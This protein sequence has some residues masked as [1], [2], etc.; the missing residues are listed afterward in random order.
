[1]TIACR[2]TIRPEAAVLAVTGLLDAVGALKVR[3]S[4]LK[5]EAQSPPAVVVDVRGMHGASDRTL[6]VFAVAAARVPLVL[7]GADED[8]TRRLRHHPVLWRVPMYPDRSAALRA[9]S[10]GEVTGQ[11][12]SI[13]LAPTP[14]APAAGRDLVD[15]ALSA[16]RLS[17]LRSEA[18]LVVS[19]LC[20]NVVRH[21]GTAMSVSLWRGHRYLHIEVRDFSRDLPETGRLPL[22]VSSLDHGRGLG[23]VA[24]YSLAWGVRPAPDGKIVWATLRLPSG[25]GSVR[26]SDPT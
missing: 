1:M 19:E 24:A 14:Q 2:T 21:A 10:G 7:S 5:V 8:L 22:E 11:R 25:V 16:W 9:V 18:E 23:L 15:R 20:G 6:L 4:L 17:A 12:W 3:R 26:R 13:D